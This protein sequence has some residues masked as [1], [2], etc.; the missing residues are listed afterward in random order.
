METLTTGYHV[1]DLG[2]EAINDPISTI[3]TAEAPMMDS[4]THELKLIITE[5]STSGIWEYIFKHHC[6]RTGKPLIPWNEVKSEHDVG[7]KHYRF[8]TTWQGRVYQAYGSDYNCQ[9]ELYE[10]I[11]Q[12]VITEEL[13]KGN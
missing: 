11:M 2:N 5:I 6:E 3:K 7:E 8:Y 12:S 10:T 13:V 9:G 1:V 4:I